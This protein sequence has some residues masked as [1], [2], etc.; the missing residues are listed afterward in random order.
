M[1]I[2]FPVLLARQICWLLMQLSRLHG[3]AR[4]DIG[5][6]DYMRK[7]EEAD[8]E[9]ATLANNIDTTYRMVDV[10]RR[11]ERKRKILED[12]LGAETV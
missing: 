5:F 3:Q 11:A 10:R 8:P 1:L 12:F 6:D 9:C 4:Q 2:P 7:M